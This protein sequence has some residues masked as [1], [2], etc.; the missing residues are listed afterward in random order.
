[1][2]LVKV[3]THDVISTWKKAFFRSEMK[4]HFNVRNTDSKCVWNF[5]YPFFTSTHGKQ[6][7]LRCTQLQCEMKFHFGSCVKFHFDVLNTCV[8][9]NSISIYSSSN[10]ACV[11]FPIKL[12]ESAIETA[13][14]LVILRMSTNILKCICKK[15]N[16]HSILCWVHRCEISLGNFHS[17][18]TPILCWVHPC[19]I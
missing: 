2:W 15:W 13:D 8:K 19:E 7:P 1:M 16:V 17:T 6:I 14:L 11:K 4:F 5:T 12:F 3:T 18:L 9:W 10:Q